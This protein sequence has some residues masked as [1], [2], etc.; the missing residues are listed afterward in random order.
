[1]VVIGKCRAA[2]AMA[3][4]VSL[5]V[6][7][8][9]GDDGRRVAQ[10]ARAVG[11]IDQVQSGGRRGGDP[12]PAGRGGA[13]LARHLGD[14][15]AG[16][17]LEPDPTQGAV[18]HRRTDRDLQGLRGLV[19][20]AVHLGGRQPADVVVAAEM[21]HEQVDHFQPGQA[22]VDP[23]LGWNRNP[24]AACRGDDPT[25]LHIAVHPHAYL[26]LRDAERI[27]GFGSGDRGAAVGDQVVEQVQ[28]SGRHGTH[29][30]TMIFR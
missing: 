23:V 29:L 9:L 16:G 19:S 10:P 22:A 25:L 6:G 14:P 17:E 28:R 11:V 15:G 7:G 18:L 4:S 12:D 24:K 1:M 21:T 5:V 8:E 27:C 2:S 3:S 26:I 13:L 30:H 20:R